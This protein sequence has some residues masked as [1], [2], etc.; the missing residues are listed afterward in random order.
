MTDHVTPV[1]AT[2]EQAGAA[3]WRGFRSADA[4]AE[5]RVVVEKLLAGPD[6]RHY[7]RSTRVYKLYQYGQGLLDLMCDTGLLSIV[8]RVLGDY[9]LVSDFSLN[10]VH[11][12]G[13]PDKWHID[14]PFNEMS[15]LVTGSPLGMQCILT[16]SPFTAE[17]G[18]T[19]FVPRSA[20][21]YALPTSQADNEYQ[22]FLA[23]PGDLLLMKA[24][25]WH[26]AG[27]N[28]TAT[29]RTAVLFS[30]VERW[31]RPMEDPA[32]SGTW[33]QT[34]LARRLLGVERPPEEMALDGGVPV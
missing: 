19:Q 29:A 5:L 32:P 13:M 21:R 24:S 10:Q 20:L 11:H 2:L 25:T 15:Q 30:F 17:T 34:L 31:V 6:S 1:L 9:P 7:P 12:G 26:R 14:Y 23:E 33:S 28:H 27:V 18:A 4:C 8:E 22:T 3:I 16:L